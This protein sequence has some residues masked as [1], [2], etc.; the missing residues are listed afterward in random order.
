MPPGRLLKVLGSATASCPDRLGLFFHALGCAVQRLRCRGCG[1]E[2]AVQ[3]LRCSCEGRPLTLRRSTPRLSAYFNEENKLKVQIGLARG[4]D[5]R[6]KRETIKRR[7]G[8]REVKRQ[9]K[10]FG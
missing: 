9:I 6:D 10:D 7:E 1:A 2:A 3:R 4:K 8:E 5:L